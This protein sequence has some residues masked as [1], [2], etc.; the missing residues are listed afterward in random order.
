MYI[1]D[2]L[3]CCGI[4]ELAEIQDCDDAKHVLEEVAEGHK[5]KFGERSGAWD[6]DLL[7]CHFIFS[8]AYKHSP[9]G[10]EL[11]KLIKKLKLGRLTSSGWKI[12]PNSGNPVKVWIWTPSYRRLR[13]WY[14]KE[15]KNG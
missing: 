15:H 10:E 2:S 13:E 5:I 4:N 7:A 12:N 9:Y 3:N 11:A 6:Q 1:N 14:E 8:Q